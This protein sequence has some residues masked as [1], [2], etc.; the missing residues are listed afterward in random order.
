MN[1]VTIDGTFD[2][3]KLRRV[4]EPK[5]LD[6]L[7]VR[8]NDILFNATNSPE[9]V[10][11]NAVFR[12]FSEP[13][14]FSNHFIRLRL[15]ER[16]ADSGLVSRWLT[17]QWRRGIFRS[18]CRQWVNQASLN[19]EQLLNLTIRL[20]PLDE[21]RRIAEILDRADDLRRKRRE[22]IERL[23]QL[24]RAMF[25]A[26]FDGQNRYPHFPLSQV[27]DLITDGT[28][29]TP[30]YADEGNIFLSARNVTSKKIDWHD[31]KY[32]PASLHLELQKRVSPRK[33]DI[34]LAKNGTT[35]VAALVDRDIVFDIYVSLALL[36]PGASLAPTYLLMALN[37]PVC[38]KQFR[39]ALKGIGVP[40][41]H[42]KDCTERVIG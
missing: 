26:D 35:G 19:K 27:C 22:G 36:R 18:M 30:T 13:V 28:H 29:Y 31:V 34:L 5:K 10:G 14:T 39:A 32:I 42:L 7:I 11:K 8:S 21:Q 15:D 41:L 3:S 23:E 1:N 25:I 16:L 12:G 38:E 40:N 4:P 2:W 6:E 24:T 20:P 9:L 33:N 37:S 17:D